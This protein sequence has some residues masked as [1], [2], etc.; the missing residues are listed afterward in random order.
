MNS[1]TRKIML[2]VLGL[3]IIALVVG[4]F[5]VTPRASGAQAQ[6]T[7]NPFATL[8]NELT[9]PFARTQNSSSSLGVASSGEPIYQSTDQYENDVV[10]AV[11]KTS[12]AVVS[13]TISENVPIVEN[14]PYDPLSD[15]PQQFQQFFGDD[16]N[17]FPTST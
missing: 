8:W 1:K 13:I 7:A 14:C 12:P 5:W 6:T 9:H 17:G 4:V 16:F 10:S 2:V 15:L 11:K 3:I